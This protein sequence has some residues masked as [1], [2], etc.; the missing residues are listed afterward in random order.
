[1][2]ENIADPGLERRLAGGSLS[3]AV[4]IRM[5]SSKVKEYMEVRGR[6]SGI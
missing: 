1:M 5:K 6:L 2:S 3:K 4:G